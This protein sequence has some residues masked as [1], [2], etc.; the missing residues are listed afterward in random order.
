M[1][2]IGYGSTGQ[3]GPGWV[4]VLGRALYK[5][6]LFAQLTESL[7]GDPR[8]TS[9]ARGWRSFTSVPI[10][11]AEVTLEVGGQVFCVR[12]DKGGVLDHRLEIDLEPGNHQVQMSLPGS[13]TVTST[14][15]VAPAGER[16][17]I[18]CDVDDTIMVTALPRPMLAAWNS[19]VLSEHARMATPGMP[20]LLDRL[21]RRYPT[22][23]IMYLSTG[24]WNVAPTLERFLARNAY[25][26]GTLLLTDWGPTRTRWFRSGAAHKVDSLR[27]LVTEF[28][29]TKWILIGDDGQ[30]DPDIYS[31]FALRYPEHVAAIVIRNLTV[32]ESVLAS[33]RIW[34]DDRAKQV[35]SGSLWM[36]A[37]DGASLTARLQDCG[38]L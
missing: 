24:A 35:A 29:E 8:A 30:R 22:A 23:P 2:F 15:Y 4:R 33:G 7:T 34:A 12:T 3:G 19:F 14:V 32:G 20:V 21:H 18:I 38:L 37:N 13:E 25:P 5:T 16:V 10:S 31:G 26:S 11:F 17:G 28:P 6:M 36:E 27:R 9:P 1:P